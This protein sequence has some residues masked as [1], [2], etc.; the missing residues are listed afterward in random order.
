MKI[1]P[2][3]TWRKVNDETVILNLETS[4]YYTVNRTGA[5]IWELLAKGRPAE[6]IA[7]A[8]AAEYELSPGQAAEDVCEFLKAVSDLKLTEAR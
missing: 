4:V 1:S 7:Q 3:V 2:T 8:L 5:L 6:K